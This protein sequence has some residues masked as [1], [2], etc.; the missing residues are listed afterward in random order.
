MCL[1]TSDSFN[2]VFSPWRCCSRCQ[3]LQRWRRSLRDR[4]HVHPSVSS[5]SST[6]T[7]FICSCSCSSQRKNIIGVYSSM[8]L[9][10]T[11]PTASVAASSLVL[12][13]TCTCVNVCVHVLVRH[14]FILFVFVF[15]DDYIPYPRIEEVRL[16][17]IINGSVCTHNT[18]TVR[19][20]RCG[21]IQGGREKSAQAALKFQRFRFQCRRA[22][23]R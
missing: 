4:R 23:D 6:H 11:T 20:R 2:T 5:C 1:R 19:W 12:F 13:I 10:T 17:V 16:N 7:S 8:C 9:S 18:L 14:M 21:G 15:Q 22:V 3:K